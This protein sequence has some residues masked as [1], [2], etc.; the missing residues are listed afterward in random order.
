MQH[1]AGEK[2]T[3]GGMDAAAEL[4]V[5]IHCESVFVHTLAANPM[6]HDS[7]LSHCYFPGCGNMS[8]RLLT[9]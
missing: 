7:S 9:N 2:Q 6:M 4:Q 1:D 5:C 3:V 8:F